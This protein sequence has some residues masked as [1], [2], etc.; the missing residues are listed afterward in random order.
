MKYVL[1][2][3]YSGI[4]NLSQLSLWYPYWIYLLLLQCWHGHKINNNCIQDHLREHISSVM[5][6]F[7][8]TFPK[9]TSQKSL[10]IWK[11]SVISTVEVDYFLSCCIFFI[12]L[13]LCVPCASASTKKNGLCQS[14]EDHFAVTDLHFLQFKNIY[15]IC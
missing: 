3:G 13:D 15:C 14:N 1:V 5:C 8:F 2:S 6:I 7:I 4:S 9:R 10:S 12:G 11:T